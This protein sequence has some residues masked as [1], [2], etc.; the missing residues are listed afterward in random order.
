MCIHTAD[1]PAESTVAVDKGT[2]AGIAPAV[3]VHIDVV[4]G[5]VAACSH[6]AAGAAAVGVVAGT[7]LPY[8]AADVAT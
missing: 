1:A 2:A 3:A 4:A 8:S 5:L 7:D 6:T